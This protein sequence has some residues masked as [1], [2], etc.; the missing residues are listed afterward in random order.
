MW[1]IKRILA[2]ITLTA[3][4]LGITA[5]LIIGMK[6]TSTPQNSKLVLAF[7]YPWY[8]TPKG[9]T[10][11]WRHWSGEGHNPDRFID[12]KRDLCS[13][14]YPINGPYDSKNKSLIAWHLRLAEEIGLDGFIVSWWGFGSFE[15]E[16]FKI[17]LDVAEEIGTTVKLTIYYEQ[18]SSTN[19]S[20]MVHEFE[21]ILRNYG[22]R[23][24]FLKVEGRP[25]IFIYSRAINQIPLSAWGEI[26]RR[27]RSDGYDALFIADGMH[28]KYFDGIHIYNPAPSLSKLN[29][30][31]LYIFFRTLA[32]RH[33]AIF[34]ATVL[35]GYDDTNIRKPGL[36]YPRDNGGTYN[37]TWKAA[38][39]SN[40]DWILI[41]SWNEWH[42][43]T[44]IEPSVEY[45]YFYI[46]LT[47][48]YVRIFKEES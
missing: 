26:I 5:Y 45:G 2:G 17:M 36:M 1:N 24:S 7:Y 9:P 3:I 32:D 28:V 42:E 37:E 46:N 18:A 4:F 35:P 25:V 8:G 13:T 23:K 21:E 40:P 41:C 30:T 27:I 33:D 22:G 14:H 34:A 11:T 10:G 38:L 16:A 39:A 15:D 43:G 44:E 48:H 29:L 19:V 47:R 12:G 31:E 6:P 20:S